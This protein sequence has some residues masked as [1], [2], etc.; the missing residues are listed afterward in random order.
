[1]FLNEPRSRHNI[2]SPK[3]LECL[4][5]T[6]VFGRYSDRNYQRLSDSTVAIHIHANYD[7]ALVARTSPDNS[8]NWNATEDDSLYSRNCLATLLY[9]SC[10][11][12]V[13]HSRCR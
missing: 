2:D 12:H 9:D 13:G 5:G 3:S 1:M 6:N 8:E 4:R 10:P 11:N 7:L